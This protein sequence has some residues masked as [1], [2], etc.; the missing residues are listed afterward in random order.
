MNSADGS[1][2]LEDD[3]LLAALCEELV[4]FM[5]G[6]SMGRLRFLLDELV[7]DSSGEHLDE[8]DRQWLDDGLRG[9][10]RRRDTWARELERLADDGVSVVASTGPGYPVNLTLVHDGPP[11]LF[12]KGNLREQDRRA[13]AVVGTRAASKT[14]LDLAQVVSSG[15]VA[16]GYAV[17][18]GLA[19]GIDTAAHAAALNAGGRT[20][21]VFGTPIDR[22]YPVANRPLARRIADTGACVSQFLPGV[23]TGPWSFPARNLTGSGLSLATVVVE[24]SESSGA[25]HQA[26]AALKHGKR[27]FLVDSLVTAQPWA[28]QMAR[29]SCNAM[30]VRDAE[31]IV[32]Q[33]EEDLAVDD[34]TVFA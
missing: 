8:P 29:D 23:R 16:H 22:V 34:Q 1:A 11:L 3:A 5:N 33:L 4:P 31:E 28:E 18:S 12:Y 13:V 10:A 26:Q 6:S 7:L 14:G 19:K 32:Q 25:R 2:V 9:A 17:V 21:A 30:V 20:I 24:A 27:V 15:L